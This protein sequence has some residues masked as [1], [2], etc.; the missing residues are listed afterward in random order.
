LP[1][2]KS[3]DPIALRGAC[4]AAPSWAGKQ[5]DEIEVDLLHTTE[6]HGTGYRLFNDGHL[7]TYDDLEL[8]K[9]DAG[10]MKLEKVAGSWRNRGPV[11]VQGLEAVR[12]AIGAT[13]EREMVGSRTG[14]GG[15]KDSRTHMLIVRDG[16]RTSFC[17]VGDQAPKGL[18]AVERAIHDLV[19]YAR[20]VAKDGGQ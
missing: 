5:S 13:D 18:E 6:A 7:E 9:S 16:K 4:P 3:V 2:S 20:E 8:I 10:R 15:G 12:R 11:D 19:K 1:R 14:Q 17:Y